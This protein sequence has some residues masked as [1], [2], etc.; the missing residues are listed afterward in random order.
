MKGPRAITVCVKYEYGCEFR[1]SSH[2]SYLFTQQRRWPV[3]APTDTT[4]QTDRIYFSASLWFLKNQNLLVCKRVGM[5]YH[6]QTQ[7]TLTDLWKQAKSG[8]VKEAEAETKKRLVWGFF[9]S[10]YIWTPALFRHCVCLWRSL[11]PRFALDQQVGVHGH[12]SFQWSALRVIWERSHWHCSQTA[13]KNTCM[14]LEAFPVSHSLTH[15]HTKQSHK[16]CF[17]W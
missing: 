8:G 5:K 6:Q 9:S 11:T 12:F 7:I 17:T 16:A 1:C 15:T 3:V 13:V 4:V 14:A 2:T 10:A